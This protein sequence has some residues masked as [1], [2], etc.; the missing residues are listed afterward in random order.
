VP[1]ALESLDRYHP[2]RARFRIYLRACLD[3]F[4]TNER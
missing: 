3:G 1:D 4:A 2:T